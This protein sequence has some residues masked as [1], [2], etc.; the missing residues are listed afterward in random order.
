MAEIPFLADYVLER[1][2]VAPD[3]EPWD[4]WL[5][6]HRIELNAM[7]TPQFIEWLDSKMA[8]YGKLVP[9]CA[10]RTRVMFNNSARHCRAAC[11]A[12]PSPS[13][14]A[15]C[16][17]KPAE[18]SQERKRSMCRCSASRLSRQEHPGVSRSNTS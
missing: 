9:R 8:G 14:I 12:G 2:G 10:S 13:Q 4:E 16:I 5:Q 18:G 17:L 3:G 11:W 1:E 7:T 15:G 6:T